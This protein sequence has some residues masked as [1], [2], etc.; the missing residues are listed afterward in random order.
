MDKLFQEFLKEKKYLQGVTRKTIVWYESSFKAYKRV[1]GKSEAYDGRESTEALPTKHTLTHFVIGL[2]EQGLEPAGVNYYVRGMN[3]FLTWLFEN[4]HCQQLRIKK[5][6]EEE[7]VI[8]TFSESQ[9]Q[10]IV[11]F[12][13]KR[14]SERRL[15]SLLL[16][17]IDSGIRIDEGL[18]LTRQN[19]DLDGLIIKVMG[20]G[21]K[22]RFVPIS[23]ECRKALFRLLQKHEFDLV[24]AT[25]SGSA[26]SYRNALRGFKTLADKLGITGV[27]VS[28][29]IL[30]H[31]FA[32]NYVRYGG[33]VLYLQ[34]ALGHTDL[35]MT[36]R[37]VN[38]QTED[39]KIAHQRTSILS[40]LR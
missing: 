17:L 24:F 7:K 9:L 19:V 22:E 37:Y 23:I 18:T 39:L 33:N 26:L 2:R 16:L 15:H 4:G 11:D 32:V 25:R 21:R 1:L 20:K 35:S 30:R 5:V 38:L 8:Q 10:A 31:T 12:K 14:F 36:R 40:R 6:K 3:V 28:F 13:P 27:Q 29:H 34:R